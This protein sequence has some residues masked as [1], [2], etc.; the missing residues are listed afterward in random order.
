M[1]TGAT[2]HLAS[3]VLLHAGAASVHAWVLART[4]DAL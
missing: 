1:T 2:L 3:G 4:T